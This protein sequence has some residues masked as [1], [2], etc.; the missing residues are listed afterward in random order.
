M[1]VRHGVGCATDCTGGVSCRSHLFNVRKVESVPLKFAIWALSRTP[2]PPNGRRLRYG[3]RIP[4]HRPAATYT[5]DGA[6]PN[7]TP[8]HI[9]IFGNTCQRRT[10]GNG[11]ALRADLRERKL[12]A[13]D[14]RSAAL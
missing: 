4:P 2:R 12:H 8:A 14:A 7:P 5:L 6:D 3:G 10:T 1:S 13:V 9:T 11:Y